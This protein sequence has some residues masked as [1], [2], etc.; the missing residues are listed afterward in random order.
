MLTTADLKRIEGKLDQI[1]RDQSLIID[2]FGLSGKHKLAPVEIEGMAK[3]IISKY[4]AKRKRKK[5]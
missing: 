1:M 2:A 5:G 3:K 4:R